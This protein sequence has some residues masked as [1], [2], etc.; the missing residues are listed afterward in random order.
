MAMTDRAT[1]LMRLRSRARVE[2]EGVV[3]GALVLLGG[4]L[5]HA[6]AATVSLQFERLL[7]TL[8]AGR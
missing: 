3:I 8:V 7:T 5:W 6:L 4:Y 1:K 2:S